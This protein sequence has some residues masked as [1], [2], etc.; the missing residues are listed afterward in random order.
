MLD[1]I[2]DD[3]TEDKKIQQNTAM[4]VADVMSQADKTQEQST[5]TLEEEKELDSSSYTIDADFDEDEEKAVISL[6]ESEL[7][8]TKRLYD[9]RDLTT[10][11]SNADDEY[12]GTHDIPEDIDNM[13]DYDVKLLLT[14]VTIDIIAS[15][16]YRQTWSPNPC[17]QME[18]EFEDAQDVNDILNKRVNYLDYYLRNINKLQDISVPIYRNAGKYGY[19]IVKTC[20]DNVSENFTQ[21]KFYRP[22]QGDI[23]KFEN[24]YKKK[25]LNQKSKEFKEWQTLNRKMSQG[26]TTPIVKKETDDI[27]VF[28]GAISR[29][30]DWR[31]FFA[32]SDIKDFRKHTCIS[33]YFSWN[34]YDIESKIAE[35]FWDADKVEKF[36]AQYKKEK[37][38]A[39]QDDYLKKDFD[40]YES[41]VLFD[42]TGEGKRDRYIVTHEAKTKT[43]VRA[44]YYPY[45]HIFYT[46]YNLFDESDSWIS[47]S[48][49]ERMSDI[50]AVA[51]SCITSFVKE[52]D[53]AHTCTLIMWHYTNT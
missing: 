11:N 12:S 9:E 29:L 44:I 43:I 6:I 8:R 22:T 30:I 4:P 38:D 5:D 53:M 49:T 52:Q 32:R 20:Y 50:I 46:S 23:A 36:I 25:M 48:I 7:N 16:A 18:A 45:R 41:V 34:W 42:R 13:S 10:K 15:R 1:D 17:I 39:S 14:T 31:N 27:V 40:F 51:N 37:S 28:R 2:K 21:K 35:G 24:K 26:D 47:F 19:Q 33:E 3:M